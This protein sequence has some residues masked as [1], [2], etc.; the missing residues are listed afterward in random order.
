VVHHEQRRAVLFGQFLEHSFGN[1]FT[2]GTIFPFRLQI[3][4]NLAA[5]RK[6]LHRLSG[7]PKIKP[8]APACRSEPWSAR[9]RPRFGSTRHVAS[10]KAVSCHR[11]PWSIHQYQHRR[12]LR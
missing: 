6:N 12:V 11:T 9:T 2:S 7:N 3:E 1:H 10:R 5:L 8:C 4:I